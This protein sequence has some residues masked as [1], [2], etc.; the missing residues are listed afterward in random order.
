MPGFGFGKGPN[1]PCN[2]DG[3]TSART[4]PYPC[5]SAYAWWFNS[6]RWYSDSIFNV[7]AEFISSTLPDCE[8]LVTGG[9]VGVRPSL[10]RDHEAYDMHLK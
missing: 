10:N 6:G 7:V 3:L 8:S 4:Y 5:D 2:S 1:I 9:G